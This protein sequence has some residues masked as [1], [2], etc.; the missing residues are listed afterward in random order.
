MKTDSEISERTP[1]TSNEELIIGLISKNQPLLHDYIFALSG[2]LFLTD[3]ILQETNLVLWRKAC[4]YDPRKPFLPWARTIAWN[5]VRAATR[6]QSRDRLLFSEDI[7]LQLTE[8]S[9]NTHAYAP[10][11]KEIFLEQCILSLTQK[12]QDLLE[13][14]YQEELGLEEMARKFR[15]S[16]RSLAQHLYLIRQILKRCIQSKIAV[17]RALK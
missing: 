10:S 9:N 2:D 3:D 5:Q 14:H 15:R 8:E 13:N 6:D 7:M 4:E 16:Q 12:Q 11:H 17:A 1:G